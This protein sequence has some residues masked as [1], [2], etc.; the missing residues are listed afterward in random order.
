M[1]SI[2]NLIDIASRLE[3]MNS[4][5]LEL[6]IGSWNSSK[7]TNQKNS[8]FFGN[9]EP[10]K[11]IFENSFPEDGTSS[12]QGLYETSYGPEFMNPSAGVSKALL[13]VMDEPPAK[14]ANSCSS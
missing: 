5:T 12:L 7:S 13:A 8:N 3:T 2:V 1:P 10:S 4:E 6:F 14:K 9:F 11:C